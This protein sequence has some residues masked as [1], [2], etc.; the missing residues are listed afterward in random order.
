MFVTRLLPLR[1]T[2]PRDDARIRD[3][4]ARERRGMRQ[5]A[6]RDA[7]ACAMLPDAV[8][9]R[10]ARC[11]RAAGEK[12]VAARRANATLQICPRLYARRRK[13]CYSARQARQ[14][15]LALLLRYVRCVR[16]MMPARR[17]MPPQFTSRCHA[18]TLC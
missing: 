11:L 10:A 2:T 8:L 3:D 5:S 16:D 18:A 12:R 13:R 1:R 9:R 4:A 14:R 7:Y 15:A 17:L 6:L